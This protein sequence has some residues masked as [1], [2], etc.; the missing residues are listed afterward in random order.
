[1]LG[2]NPGVWTSARYLLRDD[3]L[4]FTVTETTVALG[5]RQEMEYRNHVEANFIIDGEGELTD[6]AT[7]TVYPLSAGSM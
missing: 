6:F 2:E 4:G 5:Q 1:M 7:G 3:G